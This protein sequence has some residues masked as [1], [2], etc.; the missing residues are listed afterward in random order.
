[1]KQTTPHHVALNLRKAREALGLSQV[2]AAN[3]LGKTQSYISRC[4]TGKRRLDIFELE[5]FA[6]LYN[7]PISYFLAEE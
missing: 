3:R 2:E 5:A 7:K 1:M 4:E 6:R